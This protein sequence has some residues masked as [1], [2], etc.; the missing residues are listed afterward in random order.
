MHTKTLSEYINL[1]ASRGKRAFTSNEAQ[2]ALGISRHALNGSLY[3]LKKKKEIVSP[4]KNFYL[5][6]PPEDQI[7]GCIPPEDFVPLLMQHWEIDYYACLLTAAK[8]HGA[9]HQAVQRF[10]VMT[11]EQRRRIHCG[12]IVVDFVVNKYLNKTPTTKVTVRTGYLNIS[13]PEGTA[14]DILCYPRQ[15][16]GINHIATVLT[17][18]IESIDY[19]K[20]L[21]LVEM[22]DSFSWIQRLGYLLEIIDPLETVQRDKCVQI[23]KE[24]I[25]SKPIKK[26][27]LDPSVPDRGCLFHP[28]WKIIINTKVE[29]DI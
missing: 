24:F 4:S 9:T 16:G 6:V 23:L 15:S 3:R 27:P 5:I 25:Y 11:K 7:W 29:S 28:N 22:S 20:L 8:Y 26:I 19:Q 21:E 14:K 10:F 18:L 1:L 2:S 17:E 12:K 13:T